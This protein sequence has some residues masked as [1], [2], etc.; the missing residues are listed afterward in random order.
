[1]DGPPQ[2]SNPPDVLLQL[3]PI[4]GEVCKSLRVSPVSMVIIQFGD[5]SPDAREC[6]IAV[7]LVLKASHVQRQAEQTIP[8]GPPQQEQFE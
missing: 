8:S 4:L 2:S 7:L 5:L 3:T 1:M 6:L